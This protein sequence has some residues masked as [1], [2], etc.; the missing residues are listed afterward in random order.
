MEG[1][2]KEQAT[3]GL[4]LGMEILKGLWREKSPLCV[5]AAFANY[6]YIPEVQGKTSTESKC[7]QT[8]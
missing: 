7:F 3:I 6:K 1:T 2:R 8:G 5:N 4:P